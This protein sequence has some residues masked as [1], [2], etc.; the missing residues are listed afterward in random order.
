MREKVIPSAVLRPGPLGNSCQLTGAA[1]PVSGVV[2]SLSWSMWWA[3]LGS[4][5]ALGMLDHVDDLGER[6]RAGV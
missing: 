6:R 2:T 5:D 1:L 3:E 4:I